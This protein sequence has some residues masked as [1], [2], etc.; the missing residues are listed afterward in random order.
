MTFHGKLVKIALFS[1]KMSKKAPRTP[2]GPND[3]EN[4]FFEL[5]G[6]QNPMLGKIILDLSDIG[7]KLV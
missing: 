1:R 2:L 3:H 7:K 6:Y 4:N 5:P